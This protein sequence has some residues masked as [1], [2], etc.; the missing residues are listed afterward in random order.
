[1]LIIRWLGQACF[2]LSTLAGPHALS[3]VRILI[4]PPAPMVGY[5]IAAHSIPAGVV[6][7]SHD[8]PDHNYVEAARGTSGAFGPGGTPGTG[9]YNIIRPSANPTAQQ[10]D[11]LADSFSPRRIPIAPAPVPGWEKTGDVNAA[12]EGQKPLMV[13]YERIFAYHDNVQG[14]KRGTDIITVCQT[15]GLRVCHLGDLGQLALTPTQVKEIGHVDILMIPVG[16]FFTIDGPQAAAIVRQ[17]HPRVILPMHYQ[18]P[19][20]NP[21]LRTKLAPPDSF[22]KAMQRQAN[23]VHVNARDLRLS[24]RTLPKTPTIYLLRYQ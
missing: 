16:G 23:I 13:S 9:R 19:A 10:F 12:M 2:I 6:F 7:V 11:V 24:P 20:L 5:P 18:T 22:I 3:G 21:D 15:G 8:H 1:M 14:A 4:D 17:L